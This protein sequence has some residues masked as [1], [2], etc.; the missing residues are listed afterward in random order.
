MSIASIEFA[1]THTQSM[2]LRSRPLHRRLAQGKMVAI[3]VTLVA[4]LLINTSL[5]S[6]GQV[7]ASPPRLDAIDDADY[8]ADELEHLVPKEVDYID[9]SKQPQ[10]FN[11]IATLFKSSD[12]EI[13]TKSTLTSDTEPQEISRLLHRKPFSHL[14]RRSQQENWTQVNPTFIT[15]NFQSVPEIDEVTGLDLNELRRSSRREVQTETTTKMMPT[16]SAA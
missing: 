10:W 1:Y 15:S 16:T 3:V 5:T 2:K 4:V 11:R 6:H 8:Q 7:Q 13:L 9:T 14:G 12:S